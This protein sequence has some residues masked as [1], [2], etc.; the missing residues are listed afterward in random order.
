M[1]KLIVLFLILTNIS[2]IFA[3]EKIT[4]EVKE[5]DIVPY[6]GILTTQEIWQ[7]NRN[8]IDKLEK[9]ISKAAIIIF[10]FKDQVIDLKQ[11]IDEKTSEINE[12]KIKYNIRLS[13]N[14]MDK[15]GVWNKILTFTTVSGWTV[16]FSLIIGIVA[17]I[18]MWN[19]L[20]YFK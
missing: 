5:G 7:N 12:W 20:G 17:S 1:K 11:L 9:K 15:M 4:Q 14:N 8:Y 2:I 10:K 13:I 18:V 3:S 19:Y 6:N 16:A